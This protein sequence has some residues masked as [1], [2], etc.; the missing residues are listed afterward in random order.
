VTP[1]AVADTTTTAVC[2]QKQNAAHLH[3]LSSKPWQLLSGLFKPFTS[4]RNAPSL[5]PCPWQSAYTSPSRAGRR[6]SRQ[7]YLHI[8][9]QTTMMLSDIHVTYSVHDTQCSSQTWH[10]HWARG[11]GR[12][13]HFLGR[14]CDDFITVQPMSLLSTA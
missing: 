13:Q 9:L 4:L 2:R 3:L 8:I 11:F 14:V 10:R 7:C 1:I 6:I 12:R 5:R